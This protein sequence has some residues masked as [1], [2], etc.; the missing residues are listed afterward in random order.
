[1]MHATLYV[2]ATA[3]GEKAHLGM[4]RCQKVKFKS[5]ALATAELCLAEGIS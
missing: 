5:I 4:K 2:A 1:M 3:D